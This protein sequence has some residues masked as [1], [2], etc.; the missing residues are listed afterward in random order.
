MGEF[1]GE[2]L[3]SPFGAE[4]PHH[5]GPSF[6]PRFHKKDRGV[7]ALAGLIELQVNLA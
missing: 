5:P 7:D 3:G 2:L 6:A 1:V 4:H